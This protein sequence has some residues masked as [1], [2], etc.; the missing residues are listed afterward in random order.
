MYR[1]L[2]FVLAAF[3]LAAC[4]S[5]K[6]NVVYPDYTKYKSNDFDLRVMKA[7]N[8]E[9]YKQY[10]EARD[11]FLSLYQD[12]NNTNFLENAF[13]LSLANNL[14]KQAELD[15]LAKPYLNQNDN[16]KRLSALYALNSNDI[17]NAQKLMKELLTKK[18][19]DPRN[20]ELYGDI[21]VKKNDLKNATKYYRSAYNQ[22]QNEEI[23]FKLIG[24]YAILNDTL[25]IK[26]VLEFSRKTN[27]CT[28]KTCVLLAKIYFD[29]KNIEA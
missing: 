27:G 4:G 16:L 21:L 2:L 3:F 10:K 1:Y 22:V 14:D 13:L 17:N 15:N 19:S 28:L 20:L 18:D 24:I 12:Y 6:I 8:Y 29:E 23:L 11:E 5:S 26:N 9:Y 7:Y 25:N